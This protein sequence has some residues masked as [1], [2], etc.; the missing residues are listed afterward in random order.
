MCTVVTVLS[1][2]TTCRLVRFLLICLWF[3]MALFLMTLCVLSGNGLPCGRFSIRRMVLSVVE[4]GLLLTV[5]GY[6][7]VRVWVCSWR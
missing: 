7:R 5:D 3:L 6:C 4:L 2:C 1:W